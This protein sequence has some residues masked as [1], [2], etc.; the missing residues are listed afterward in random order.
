MSLPP[1][2]ER[3]AVA[4]SAALGLDVVARRL[5]AGDLVIAMYHGFTDEPASRRIENHEGK[6]TPADV[7]RR[8]VA[9]LAGHYTILSLSDVVRRRAEGRPLPRRAAV[10]TID[11]GYQSVARVAFPVLREFG[12]PATVFLATEFVDDGV[13]L[14][15]D[16][17]E[18][19]IGTS[20]R[21]AVVWRSGAGAMRWEL[22]SDEAR[23]AADRQARTAIKRLPQDEQASAVAALEEAAGC[24]LRDAPAPSAIYRPMSWADAR[25][26]A[27]S[28][29]IRFGSHTH[30]HV[31]LSRTTRARAAR[32]LATSKAII[33]SRLGQPCDLF[34]YP[35]GRRGDFDDATRGLVRDAGFACAL[36][37]VYG[38]NRPGADLYALKRYNLGRMTALAEV[39]VRVAGLL[40]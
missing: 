28:G 27:E 5:H 31:I 37:T 40:G 9:W 29:L 2:V 17:V 16:R 21:A 18:Y 8:Q 23:R 34:C 19:A 13:P 32:E 12:A 3:A 39:R 4:A 20:S 15:T 7:F 33:E 36:T 11:D 22:S 10:I 38:R 30:A 14:W 26:L 1:V 24:C 25:A 6:H 35:N